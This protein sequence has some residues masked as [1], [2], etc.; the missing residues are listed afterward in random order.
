MIP[1]LLAWLLER[2]NHLELRCR[3]LHQGK[4]WGWAQEFH[5]RHAVDE[6][7]ADIYRQ[8]W[9]V[10]YVRAGFR[11]KIQLGPCRGSF[12][13]R[14]LKLETEKGHQGNVDREEKRRSEDWVLEVQLLEERETQH[15]TVSNRRRSRKFVCP[16]FSVFHYHPGFILRPFSLWCVLEGCLSLL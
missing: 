10:E 2:S 4:V 9:V 16:L 13:Y 3:R 5:F 15:R 8:K 7:P 11:W 6:V 1:R 14:Y 12:A